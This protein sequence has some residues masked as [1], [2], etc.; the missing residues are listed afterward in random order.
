MMLR[1]ILLAASA[2]LLLSACANRLFDVGGTETALP[3]SRAWVD[4]RQVEYVTTDVSDAGMARMLGINHVPRL[5]D[6]I[7]GPGRTSVVERVYKFAGGEQPSV[8]QSAPSPT[9]AANAD[10][11]YSPLWRM[12]MVRWLRPTGQHELRSEEQV[13]A[14]ADRGEVALDIT[15]IVINC[16]ITRSVDA[17]ALKGV[18]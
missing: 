12:V 5:A 7:A 17:Q 18:R 4:G 1:Q 15:D 6:A 2:S 3:L 11:N 13:L 9:G 14:A 10:R 8:F 16:P